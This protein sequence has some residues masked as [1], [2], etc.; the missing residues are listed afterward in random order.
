M[1]GRVIRISG[2]KC[3]VE[4]EGELLQCELRGRLKAG[5][6]KTN[7]PVVAGDWVEILLREGGGGIIEAI[8]PRTSKFSRGAS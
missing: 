7:S 4:V 6:R 1:H 5:V 8:Y 3:L 2:L